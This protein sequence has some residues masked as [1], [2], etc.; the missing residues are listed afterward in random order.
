MITLSIIIV[1]YNVKEFIS[2][3]L[4][5]IFNSKIQKEF[6]VIVV[7]NG[8]KDKT[9]KMIRKDF[10]KVYLIENNENKGFAAANNQGLNKAKGEF[11]LFLNP[12]TSVLSEAIEKSM[13]FL[14]ETPE[15]GAV[16]CKI[17]NQD[18]SLQ[19]SCKS[20]PD[21][22]NYFFESTFLYKLFPKNRLF[23]R[24][25]MTSFDYNVIREVDMVSGAFLMAPKRLIE[26]VGGWDERF[27]IYSE[28]TDLCYRIRRANK[29]IF[30]IPQAQIIHY[31]SRSTS[32]EPV[33]MFLQDHRGRYLFM[34]K[35]YN[36][37][38]IISS[39]LII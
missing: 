13:T 27:F 24:F 12:D 5:S 36:A 30:F 23:G 28:E 6:E 15:A 8:S 26:E 3:C 9:V 38:S 21:F 34:R 39:E 19:P 16:G 22:W 33:K 18:G 14:S 2:E 31:G 11:V 10:M 35:H 7:D 32:Q 25:Y 1:S 20:F 17:L 37:L 29:K 4:R